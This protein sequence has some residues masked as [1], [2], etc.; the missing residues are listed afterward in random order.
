MEYR[1]KQVIIDSGLSE[2][3]IAILEN[4]KLVEI[5]IERLEDRKIIGNIYRAKVMNVLPG[6]E[7]AFVDIGTDRNAFLH[8]DDVLQSFGRKASKDTDINKLIKVGQK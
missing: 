6:I 4:N 1:A 2:E 5:Y 3:R 8:L 7:A